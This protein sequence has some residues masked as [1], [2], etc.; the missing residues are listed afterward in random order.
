MVNIGGK[1]KTQT[2]AFEI[3]FSGNT[4]AGFALP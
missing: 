2:S 1:I 4:A 3:S